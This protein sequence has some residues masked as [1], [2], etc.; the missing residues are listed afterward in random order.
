MYHYKHIFVH[1]SNTIDESIHILINAIYF[2]LHHSCFNGYSL[3]IYDL[4]TED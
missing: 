1:H 4:Q 2:P 3:L